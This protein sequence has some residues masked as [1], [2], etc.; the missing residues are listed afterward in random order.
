[1]TDR[2][3]V[4][5]VT[6][7]VP[8]TFVLKPDADAPDA[9]L[10]KVWEAPGDGVLVLQ[11][12][13]VLP[14]GGP[15]LEE[16]VR[17]AALGFGK[18]LGVTQVG[19]A[20]RLCVGTVPA[21]GV[22]FKGGL[23][24]A[25]AVSDE[26]VLLFGAWGSPTAL[27]AV[28]AATRTLRPAL[29]VLAVRPPN[30]APAVST[31]VGAT[32]QAP[33]D[34][35]SSAKATA[36]NRARWDAPQV[37]L[38]ARAWVPVSFPAL[39]EAQPSSPLFLRA[40]LRRW[41]TAAREAL[42]RQ[43][44]KDARVVVTGEADFVF[45]DGTPGASTILDEVAGGR[46]VGR[47]VAH[48]R[49]TP[50]GALLMA[51]STGPDA[52]GWKAAPA[53][54]PPERLWERLDDVG[55]ALLAVALHASP[56]EWP[57]IDEA[58]AARLAAKGTWSY[59]TRWSH[60]SGSFPSAFTAS[61]SSHETWTFRADGTC[62]LE[63]DDFMGFSAQHESAAPG[64]A[65]QLGGVSTGLL[66]EPAGR[67]ERRWEVRAGAPALLVLHAPDGLVSAHALEFERAGTYGKQSFT[68][69]AI[70]GRVEGSYS[71]GSGPSGR[72][73]VYEP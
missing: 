35:A 39:L 4:G 42:G 31:V 15:A 27:A 49:A 71:S 12:V 68:G 7:E 11:A 46:V 28:D 67:R 62:T 21:L 51:T 34:W 10:T 37:V 50:K 53:G 63:S 47:L 3:V 64:H 54:T 33:S 19:P 56:T 61:G 73:E 58:A 55:Q 41:S 13:G 70:D 1:M 20:R 59:S 60:V 38:G 25:L 52:D 36:P 65:G 24:A 30:T 44:E 72:Y 32:T 6:L 43:L 69:L 8:E 16:R 26:V 2:V 45:P 17:A 9:D 40:A 14:P 5:K 57:A 18:R 48:A 66:D 22:P 23:G 29:D